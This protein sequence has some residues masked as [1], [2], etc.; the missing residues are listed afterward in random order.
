MYSTDS[1]DPAQ[2]LT[3][4]AF[5]ATF[6]FFLV[7]M[8]LLCCVYCVASLRTN[9]VF[10][11]IF[12]T[13][14]PTCMY[15][16]F[17]LSR[18]HTHTHSLPCFLTEDWTT[19]K[20]FSWLPVSFILRRRARPSCHGSDTPTR[21]RCTVVGGQSFGLVHLFGLGFFGR[22]LPT[23]TSVGRFVDRDQRSRR[24]SQSETSWRCLGVT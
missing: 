15:K 5:F 1:S 22:R 21:R 20:F 13:L 3:Q 9:V 14:I 16:T 8:A 12:L 2:G 18:T 23:V 17:A 7:A 4:P 24:Q 19:D 10:F 11:L 6:S